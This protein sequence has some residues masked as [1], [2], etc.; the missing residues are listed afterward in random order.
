MK[1]LIILALILFHQKQ[2]FKNTT[3]LF[4]YTVIFLSYT[5]FKVLFKFLDL[6]P[7]NVT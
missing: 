2:F 3:A 6:H 7:L 5:S 1:A 4:N